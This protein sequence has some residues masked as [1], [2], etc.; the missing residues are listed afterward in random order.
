MN[1]MDILSQQL[2]GAVADQI[3]KKVGIDGSVAQGAINAIL[4]ALIGGLS[5]NASNPDGAAAIANA[6][7]TKHDGSILNDLMGYF[8]GGNDA[9][10]E[11]GGKI[12]QHILGPDQENV[13]Q[14]LAQSS[15]LDMS[16]I[17]GLMSQL[18]PVVMGFLGQQKQQGG[19]DV[20]S[21]A[22]LLNGQQ[23]HLQSN[24]ASNPILGM[25]TGFLDQNKDGSIMDDAMSMIGNFMKK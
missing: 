9:N 21:L 7:D 20:S 5:R 19:L 12:V 18:A 22:N 14:G 16:Q 4:P 2:S 6:V 3:G 11:D 23:S 10:N 24:S 1:I 8:S 17:G 25:L 15:G 13:Q